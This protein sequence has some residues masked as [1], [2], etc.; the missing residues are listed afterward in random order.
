MVFQISLCA[1]IPL[2]IFYKELLEI[3]KLFSYTDQKH[4][5]QFVGMNLTSSVVWLAAFQNLL[6]GEL[7]L[8]LEAP[9]GL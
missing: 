1:I 7:D 5:H 8:T 9:Q 3:T 6:A 2:Y 4:L